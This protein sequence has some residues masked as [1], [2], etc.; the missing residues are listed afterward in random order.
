MSPRTAVAAIYRDTGIVLY[1]IA[2]IAGATGATVNAAGQAVPG[3]G[4]IPVF[5]VLALWGLATIIPSLALTARRLHDVN[6]ADG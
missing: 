5:I 1:I 6:P 2:G 4:A 3:P